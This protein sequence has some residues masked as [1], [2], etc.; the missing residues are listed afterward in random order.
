MAFTNDDHNDLPE[1]PDLAEPAPAPDAS[2][3]PDAAEAPESEPADE[4]VDP[5]TAEPVQQ[6]YT[7]DLPAGVTARD[8]PDGADEQLAGFA[9]AA[10][11]G[12]IPQNI[13]QRLLNAFA[14]SA[15]DLEYT[16]DGS[17]ASAR[18]FLQARWGAEY[19]SRM[20]LVHKA[21]GEFGP[22]FSSFLEESG[23]GNNPAVIE[24][25]AR[26]GAGELSLSKAD[27]Q[28]KLDAIN[29]DRTHVYWRQHNLPPAERRRL[30]A[31]MQAL[32]DAAGEPDRAE[33]SNDLVAQVRDEEARTKTKSDARTEALKMMADREGALMN[34]NHKGH[35]AALKKYHTLL[36]RL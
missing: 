8:L 36:A 14:G 29:G 12:G 5:Q 33:S 26:Y 35:A 15:F 7:L 22:A 17:L 11:E 13:A 19:G 9:Q 2:A 24:T 23:Y 20:A 28:R 1:L 25:L 34:K 27:A 21:V 31:E 6:P 3:N 30:A 18:D 16:G 4:Q 10:Q 32:V